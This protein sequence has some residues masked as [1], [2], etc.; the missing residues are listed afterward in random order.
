MKINLRRIELS[1]C[2]ADLLGAHK[3]ILLAHTH[4]ATSINLKKD[5]MVYGKA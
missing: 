2:K 4:V 1:L 5:V 3:G